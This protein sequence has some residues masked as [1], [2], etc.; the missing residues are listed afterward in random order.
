MWDLMGKVTRMQPLQVEVEVGC[1]G[2]EVEVP[3]YIIKK[4]VPGDLLCD[5]EKTVS[6]TPVHT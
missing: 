2:S 3:P 1:D 5:G 4:T 6:L